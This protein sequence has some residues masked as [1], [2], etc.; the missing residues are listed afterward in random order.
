[1]LYPDKFMN[2][3]QIREFLKSPVVQTII[4]NYGRPIWEKDTTLQEDIE[5]STEDVAGRIQFKNYGGS[6]KLIPLEYDL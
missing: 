2:Q 5:I 1:M 4:R 3:F 6:V